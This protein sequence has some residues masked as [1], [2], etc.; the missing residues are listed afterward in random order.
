MVR[1][2]I[3]R[4]LWSI[5]TLVVVAVLV[6]AGTEAL[7]GD[8]C[9]AYLGRNAT[10]HRVAKCRDAFD[11][12][13]PAYERFVD[14]A[15]GATQGDLGHSMKRHKPIVDILAPRIRNTVL[16]AALAAA[17]SI[18]TA[19]L[20]GVLAALRRDRFADLFLSTTSI[21]CMTL[22][23]FVSATLLILVFSIWLDWLPGI[24]IV[25]PGAP[26]ADMLSVIVLPCIA[27][28]LVMT[29]H[30]LRMV[31]TSVIDV[32]ESEY[33]QMA[34]LKG[35]PF[36]PRVLRHALPNAII[37]AI[38]LIALNIAWLLGGV[39]VIEVVFNYPGLGRLTIDAISDRDLP[40]IQ[41]IALVLAT[42][43]VT[44]NL[45]ADALTIA[46]NPRLRSLRT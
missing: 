43:Y 5:F 15:S 44:I 42:I 12:N 36:W 27:L 18:P 24:A 1:L 7:P 16:L 28:G 45:A 30:I 3:R 37:P 35:V 17:I 11:L 23:E 31:R 40:L 19:I 9:T 4:G 21:I 20:L 14:W 26:L 33:V 6:F 38:N 2:L 32:M 22:P 13:R 41:A 8:A 29:A 10:E 34:I 25:S 39:V 46:A